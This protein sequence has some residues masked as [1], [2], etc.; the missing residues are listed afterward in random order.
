MKVILLEQIKQ[1]YGPRLRGATLAIW[2]LAFKANTNDMREATSQVIV[3]GLIASGATVV[4]YDPVA[5]DEAR[6]FIN[7]IEYAE[8]EYDAI[9]GADAMVIVTEWN[10]FRALDLAKVKSL[11]KEPKIA[12]LRNIYDP[13]DVR[14]QYFSLQTL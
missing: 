1:H 13:E 7:G 4:A 3:P 2:G 12:D 14:A 10:Q 8:D 6:H 5:M 9:N 11:L